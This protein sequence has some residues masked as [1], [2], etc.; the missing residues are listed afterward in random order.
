MT[1]SEIL[2]LIKNAGVAGAGGAGFPAHVKLAAGAHKLIANCAECEPLLA[3]DRFLM[4]QEAA[5]IVRGLKLAMK[6]AGAS[7]GILGV[8]EKN[9]A[10]VSALTEAVSGEDDITVHLLENYYPAGDEVQLIYETTGKVVPAGAL[11]ASVGCIVQNAQTLAHIADACEGLPVTARNVTVAGAVRQPCTLKA[12]IGTSVSELIDA[13]GGADCESPRVIIGGPLMGRVAADADSEYVTK[14]T[15]GIVVLPEDHPLIRKKCSDLGLQYRIARSACCQCSYCTMICPRGQLGLGVQPNRIMQALT[16]QDAALLLN[17]DAV[18]ACCGCGLCTYVGC[19]MG[20]APD[21]FMTAMRSELLKR[22]VKTDR[23]PSP[24]NAMREFSKVPT[25][26]LMRRT[27]IL[28]Y[29]TRPVFVRDINEPRKVRIMLKQHIGEAC[30]PLVRAGD[31]VVKGTRI[32][33]PPEGALGAAVH[34]SVS[35]TV[36]T[37][38]EDYIDIVSGSL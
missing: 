6:A 24:V 22:K 1:G 18:M 2:D 13:A 28:R 36:K 8:K 15:G 29:D 7:K 31:R 38:T 23:L 32:G 4:E 5:R 27:G 19:T 9:H 25:G 26:R 17:A 33:E 11:P 34:A 12:A 3:S 20:L 16:M 21:R 14:T 30:A 10:A 35:G 37:V